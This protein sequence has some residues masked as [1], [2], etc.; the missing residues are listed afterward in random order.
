MA[1][2]NELTTR[3]VFIDS[4]L[5]KVDSTRKSLFALNTD[6][7]N[8][9]KNSSLGKNIADSI[10]PAET[11]LDSLNKKVND[12][13]HK[14]TISRYWEVEENK[15][16]GSLK[17]IENAA[18]KTNI[19][20]SNVG[21]PSRKTNNPTDKPNAIPFAESYKSAFSDIEDRSKRTLEGFQKLK[22]IKL[23]KG[24]FDIFTQGA[25]GAER[26]VN[27]L[28]NQIVR[29]RKEAA[30]IGNAK[31]EKF[32]AAEISNLES[33]VNTYERKLTNLN[34]QQRNGR[35]GNSKKRGLTDFDRSLLEIT[36]DFAPAGFNRPFNAVGKEILAVNTISLTT[37]ATFGAIAA[38]GYLIV[39]ASKKIR[40]EAE[41]RL[42]YET[43]ISAAGNK[44]AVAQKNALRDFEFSRNIQ[45]YEQNSSRAL[46]T[47]SIADLK[48]R[49]D[50]LQKLVNLNPDPSGQDEAITSFKNQIKTLD[51]LIRNSYEDRQLSR[52]KEIASQ[53]RFVDSQKQLN[54][55]E[56]EN[57]LN[58]SKAIANRD[59]KGVALVK[60]NA[61]LEIESLKKQ[62]QNNN[63]S[64]A[65]SLL[66][67]TSGDFDGQKGRQ[68]RQQ[69]DA[70]NAR[71]TNQI[72]VTQINSQKQ[73]ADDLKNSKEIIDDLKVKLNQDNPFVSFY[74]ESES[75]IRK[76]K[77]TISDP[78][79]LRDALKLQEAI[80]LKK[81]NA[82]SYESGKKALN[83]E[84]NATRSGRIRDDQFA[85]FE[86]A[87]STV[88]RKVD[89][90]VKINQLNRDISET[91]FYA[92]KYNPNNPRQ[93]EEFQRR[94]IGDNAA[95]RNSLADVRDL[96]RIDLGATG[97]A[98]EA[99]VA[100]EVL[101]VIPPL[102]DLVSALNNPKLAGDA[103]YLLEQRSNA[104]RSVRTNEQKKLNDF[105]YD[106]ETAG[107]NKKF[108]YDQLALLNNQKGLSKGE[109]AQN[110]L[111]ITKNLGNDLDPYLR[112]GMYQ[113]NLIAAKEER[114]KQ[115][116]AQEY[117]KNTAEAV[118]DIKTF[119][120][121]LITA[122]GLKIDG[123]T[124]PAPQI[125]V[126]A[127]D[128][129]VTEEN[130]PGRALESDVAKLFG[131]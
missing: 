89:F 29:L 20:L 86:R 39:D 98:G 108:A 15:T 40:E 33:Q 32:Y 97:I 34:R 81:I 44:Q 8:L 80:N 72:A 118:G 3:F 103:R 49:R 43:I 69:R 102:Q 75:A 18:I 38:A 24:Q 114:A 4:D 120:S 48:K 71:L 53:Q 51:D 87:L 22:E 101:K 131:N 130:N 125:Y 52:D 83:F 63:N 62:I 90:A 42:K 121:K 58:Y 30:R 73:I 14:P 104:L 64:A 28:T 46:P 79:L 26:K 7:N 91:D 55:Q 68:I 105:L 19:S 85:S 37:L 57:N 16:I 109:Y 27:D 36:D 93:L 100:S 82:L 84:Q 13:I 54:N 107:L 60:E 47:A 77:D 129:E 50:N 70:E 17:A 10:K 112:R 9:G 110:F 12:S 5:N 65:D 115:E 128:F 96:K 95:I 31:Y 61:R 113:Q 67:L 66:N 1:T 21:S 116:K 56:I 119:L 2:T 123:S 127:K 74:I 25:I 45:A 124:I 99:A 41:K 94:F 76:L 35:S 122:N 59:L 78:A 23:N 6:L 92:R 117:W 126:D 88:E 106:Q 11:A 111:D